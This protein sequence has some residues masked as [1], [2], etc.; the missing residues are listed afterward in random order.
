MK[1]LV[2]GVVFTILALVSSAQAEDWRIN[3]VKTDIPD[4]IAATERSRV[5][6]CESQQDKVLAALCNDVYAL[7]KERQETRR[8]WLKFSLSYDNLDKR[9]VKQK[10]ALRGV[11]TIKAYD[12]E[13][14]ETGAWIAAAEAAFSIQS[15]GLERKP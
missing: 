8:P 3:R 2:Y 6:H 4:A 1:H 15:S 7:I 5:A 12:A 9:H 10:N 11:G 13:V 14:A